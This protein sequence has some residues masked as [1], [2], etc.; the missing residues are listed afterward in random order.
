LLEEGVWRKVPSASRERA[1][2]APP[3]SLRQ[4]VNSFRS[5]PKQSFGG[6]PRLNYGSQVSASGNSPFFRS[7]T[8]GVEP[9]ETPVWEED[10][11]N[12]S[13]CSFV[14]G[15][16]NFSRRHHCRACGKCVCKACSPY[17]LPV[18]GTT[19]PQRVCKAC[20]AELL[21]KKEELDPLSGSIVSMV[22]S[23]SANPFRSPSERQINVE[24]FREN[25]GYQSC[26]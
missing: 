5:T 17:L 14:L 26:F 10:K 20:V 19:L 1:D 15:P 23:E 3:P 6:T 8:N 13:L 4:K 18:G 16:R 9:T 24:R 7:T 12:C 21:S 2:T 11:R 25:M 22:S